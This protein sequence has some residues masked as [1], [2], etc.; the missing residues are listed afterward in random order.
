MLKLC[1]IQASLLM[2]IKKKYSNKLDKERKHFS[3]LPLYIKKVLLV[4]I[5]HNCVNYCLDR[6][7]LC[8]Y[9]WLYKSWF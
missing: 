9:W 6:D 3:N 8:F 4:Y 7:V 2:E 5:E 1:T